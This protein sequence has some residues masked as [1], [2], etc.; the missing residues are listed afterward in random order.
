MDL[1]EFSGEHVTCHPDKDSIAESEG[2]DDELLVSSVE[3]VKGPSYRHRFVKP[4]R[5]GHL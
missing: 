2:A 4:S 1:A 3:D 5:W